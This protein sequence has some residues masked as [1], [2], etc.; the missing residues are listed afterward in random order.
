MAIIAK[1]KKDT[2]SE[3]KKLDAQIIYNELRDIGKNNL[4][5]QVSN[6]EVIDYARNNPNSELYKA[7]E[8]RDSV[9]AENY[10]KD[11]ARSI[12]NSLVTFELE[13]PQVKLVNNDTVIEINAFTN[14]SANN[15][16]NHAPTEIVMSKP[17]LRK[18]AL[19]K[20]LRELNSFKERYAYLTELADVFEAILQA[21][22][23]NIP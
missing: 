18:A 16:K 3:L 15:L 20:A 14:P 6:Q 17:D 11:Q 2:Y 8:W 5:E 19:E 13:N 1:W 7:F 10:R 12:K 21:N 9:A 4:Y 23:V 22:K